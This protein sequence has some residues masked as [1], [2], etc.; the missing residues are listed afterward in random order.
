[1]TTSEYYNVFSEKR[2][3]INKIN[4]LG[5]EVGL[6]CD[7]RFLPKSKNEQEFFFASQLNLLSEVCGSKVGQRHSTCQLTRQRLPMA[8][9]SNSKPILMK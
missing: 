8:A 9:G 2:A 3:L 5:H 4:N 7:T 6:H 1:M